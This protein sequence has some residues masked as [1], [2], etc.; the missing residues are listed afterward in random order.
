MAGGRKRVPTVLRELHG[1][2]RQHAIPQDEP[3]GVG[4]I[5]APPSW[6]DDAQREQWHYAVDHAPPGLLTGT[7]RETLVVWCCACVE[8]AKAVLR[9]RADGQVVT[10]K[11]GNV[12]QN[13]YLSVMNRQAL[14]M[15]KAGG[16][17]GFSPSAR[18]SLGSRGPEFN[19]AGSAGQPARTIKGSLA[20]Y[21]EQ[22]PDSLN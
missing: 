10:T 22:K 11:A 4:D 19:N 9:V 8:Y 12:I 6:F 14:I 15:L 3:E 16:E 5:W 13:P 7:D 20:G 17:M 2:P 18:A 21:L 1:N